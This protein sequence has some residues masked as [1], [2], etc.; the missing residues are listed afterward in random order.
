MPDSQVSSGAPPLFF[1]ILLWQIIKKSHPTQKIVDYELAAKD[2][3]DYILVPI[4]LRA[5]ILDRHK[6]D[7]SWHLGLALHEPLHCQSRSSHIRSERSGI[8]PPSFLLFS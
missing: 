2:N 7:T 3:F 8:S 5:A 1:D 6:S 4:S